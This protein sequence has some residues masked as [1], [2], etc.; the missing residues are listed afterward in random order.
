MRL[1]KPHD[2][3]YSC[4]H[5]TIRHHVTNQTDSQNAGALRAWVALGA[6]MGVAIGAVRGN[7]FLW[8]VIGAVAGLALRSPEDDRGA[9]RASA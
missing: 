1:W 6:G 4:L 3:G 9:G 2:L 7:V 5:S 8:I